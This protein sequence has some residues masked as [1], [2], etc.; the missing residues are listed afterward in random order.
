LQKDMQVIG[1]FAKKIAPR[2]H[3]CSHRPVYQA[4]LAGGH[5]DA[6]YRRVCAVIG[7]EGARA[8]A[9]AQTWLMGW[10]KDG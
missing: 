4:A 3:C 8:Q 5:A 2:C 10:L 1:D 9:K 7:K 6:R